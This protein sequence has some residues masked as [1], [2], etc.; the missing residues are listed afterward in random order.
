MGEGQATYEK[1]YKLV[2]LGDEAVGKTS[3]II[4][5]TEHR[6]S[7]SYKM[8]IGTDI[9]ARLIEVEEK[10]G[11]KTN[12]YLII[13]DIGGQEKYRILRESYLRGA[14]GALLVFDVTNKRSFMNIYE[15]KEEVKRFC[16]G[17]IPM[18]LLGNKIDLKENR[19]VE[20]AEGE[21]LAK[22]FGI[23]YL[24]TSAKSGTNVDKAFNRIVQLILKNIQV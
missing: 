1:V 21:K 9:S 22:E 14:S 5:H 6:F 20:Q 24:E 12:V 11:T 13:W 8:T 15:W 4:Q 3:L 2:M 18:L 7:E 16:G 23:E 10:K 19:V 17:D